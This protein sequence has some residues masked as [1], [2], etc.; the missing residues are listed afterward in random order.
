M[1]VNNCRIKRKTLSKRLYRTI[2][3]DSNASRGGRAAGSVRG[4][5]L[6]IKCAST[7][8][9]VHSC[10]SQK[11]FRHFEHAHPLICSPRK[12]AVIHDPRRFAPKLFFPVRHTNKPIKL[13]Q[14]ICEPRSRTFC[15]CVFLSICVYFI[16]CKLPMI[17]EPQLICRYANCCKRS[18]NR[19]ERRSQLI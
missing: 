2:D 8:N 18:V 11:F 10:L 17:D 16:I 14:K 4:V 7:A 1:L 9:V 12:S 6:R 15:S 3:A 19:A 13:L 5:A